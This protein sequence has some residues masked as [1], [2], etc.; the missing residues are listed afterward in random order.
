MYVY[1]SGPARPWLAILLCIALLC[2]GPLTRNALAADEVTTYRVVNVDRGD[3]LNMRAGPSS[4]Y[5]VVGSIPPAEAGIRLVGACRE[6]CQ[7]EYKGVA[8]WVNHRFLA[9]EPAV[10]PFTQ[11]APEL[12]YWRVVGVAA[13]DV[14]MVRTAP[15]REAP[16][17]HVYPPTAACVVGIGECRGPWCQVRIP[18]REGYQVGWVDGRQVAPSNAVC[19]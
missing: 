17:A 18:V 9:V 7:V 8:G 1:C 13:N 6:W 5:S 16:V 12:S 14:L 4:A 15:S 3:V 2:S 11:R 10:A 19:N